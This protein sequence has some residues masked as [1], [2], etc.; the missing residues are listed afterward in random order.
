MLKK[1]YLPQ[2]SEGSKRVLFTLQCNSLSL[3]PKKLSGFLPCSLNSS[4]KY[5]S[6]SSRRAV[7]ACVT[8][9]K[10][11]REERSKQQIPTYLY[12]LSLLLPTLCLIHFWGWKNFYFPLLALWGNKNWPSSIQ[13]ESGKVGNFL[14]QK[15]LEGMQLVQIE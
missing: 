15:W 3:I 6:L 14:V 4:I 13:H 9:Q 10:A 8:C 11:R 12:Q 5:T 1:I 2:V 7:Y